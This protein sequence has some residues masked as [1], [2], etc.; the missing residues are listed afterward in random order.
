[1][2][3]VITTTFNL[4]PHIMKLYLLIA[5][6]CILTLSSLAQDK[7]KAT[8]INIFKNG[9]YFVVKEGD[10]N[11]KN[12]KWSF[13]APTNPLLGTIW[14]TTIKDVNLKRID[15]SNDTIK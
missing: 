7:L 14:F 8:S 10:V 13:A 3:F 6:L 2:R 5:S 11:I 1:M 15:Y 12:N 9:T 4:K